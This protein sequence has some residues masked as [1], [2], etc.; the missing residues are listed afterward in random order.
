MLVS[1]LS[2]ICGVCIGCAVMTTDKP[3]S[4]AVR[5]PRVP[6]AYRLHSLQSV[7]QSVSHISPVP[8]FA[9]PRPPQYSLSFPFINK[10]T[11]YVTR[12]LGLRV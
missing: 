3:S 2:Y 8:L 4:Q 1:L 5:H 6:A 9:H 7:S 12:V 10:C 11:V